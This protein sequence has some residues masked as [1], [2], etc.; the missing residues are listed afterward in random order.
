MINM[1]LIFLREASEP[2]DPITVVRGRAELIS[3]TLTVRRHALIYVTQ[4]IER[5]VL[6]EADV[7]ET[8]NKALCVSHKPRSG[9]PQKNQNACEKLLESNCASR[10]HIIYQS[11]GYILLTREKRLA[12]TLRI[13][14][15]RLAFGGCDGAA[16]VSHV[17]VASNLCCSDH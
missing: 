10:K 14:V 15:L 16:D 8:K 13:A 6:S 4:I 7:P 9:P 1:W 17:C 2:T 12:P 11:Q 3:E 5:H